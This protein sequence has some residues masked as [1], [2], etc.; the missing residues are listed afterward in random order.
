MDVKEIEKTET[1]AK[2]QL[3][4]R[5]S[6]TNSIGLI[7]SYL[8]EDTPEL[9]KGANGMDEVLYRLG[10]PGGVYVVTETIYFTSTESLVNLNLT[11]SN[12][13]NADFII[14]KPNVDFALSVD[15]DAFP[16]IKYQNG[17]S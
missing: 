1:Y 4:M 3:V 5:K 15:E 16:A 10:V 2:V 12:T 6:L 17:N 8:G 13:A 9:L 7:A 11:A 14:N